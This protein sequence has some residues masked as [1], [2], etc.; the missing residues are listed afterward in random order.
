MQD[1][2]SIMKT[3][4]DVIVVGAGASGA[5]LASQLVA[6]GLD[7]ALV[8]A[9]ARVNGVVNRI[10][11]LAF[12]AS[13]NAATNWNFE[14][15]PIPEL[16]NRRQRWSQ[17][18]MLGGSSNL[19]GMLWMRGTRHDYAL[20]QAAGC[21]GWGWDEALSAYRAIE[22]SDRGDAYHGTS[23][24]I[25]IR[26]AGLEIP[27]EPAFLSAMAEAGLPIAE[28]INADIEEGF[29][30]FDVNIANGKR[31]GVYQAC[32][33]PL[34]DHPRL[35]VFTESHVIAL[36]EKN[37]RITG[38]QLRR[39]AEVTALNAGLEV[40]LC[41]GAL[42]TPA[43]LMASGYGPAA[44]LQQ[45]GIPLRRDCP[46]IGANLHNHPAVAL[47]YTLSQPL[48][49]ARYLRPLPAIIAALRYAFGRKGPLGE[50]YV[51]LG[52]LF[53]SEAGVDAADMMAVVMPALVKRADVGAGL[54]EIFE[55]RH[56]FAVNLSLARQK[57]RGRIR[58]NPADPLGPPVIEPGYFAE[59][60]D[61][62]AM[63]AGV[64]RIRAALGQSAALGG[65]ITETGP[66]AGAT[67]AAALERAI[68]ASC[69]TFYHPG[70]T[71]RM[72]G[73]DA[74]VDPALRLR[75]VAGLRIA[76]ASVVPLPMGAS[77]HAPSVLIGWR[78]AG[79]ILA[80]HRRAAGRQTQGVI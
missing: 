30:S 40:A 75:G 61:L 59:P 2:S 56:G 19:N 11:A 17:G 9:G 52:G 79:L 29:G 25:H 13:I 49:A 27:L 45:A 50:S 24:P 6:G 64:M 51:A 5:M 46:G 12:M 22:S 71:C 23:G 66:L 36:T 53:C 32:L 26:R 57:S 38:V 74:P 1:S 70:G 16:N 41:C 58:L 60:A 55:Y 47:R 7:V 63:T 14:T 35:S 69:G 44:E 10:P 78:A 8:E 18:R 15:A 21:P 20:W 39:G 72:G 42:L 76:D 28:D 48:S 65:E 62:R 43:L 68:R 4:F 77:M 33:M 34:R 67:D 54:S 31:C 73:E 3:S 80:D 37:G